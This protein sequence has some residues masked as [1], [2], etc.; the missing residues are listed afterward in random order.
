MN[1]AFKNIQIITHF[2]HVGRKHCEKNS[3]QIVFENYPNFYMSRFK[4][5]DIKGTQKCLYDA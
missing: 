1:A 4:I 5:F 2:F 3:M